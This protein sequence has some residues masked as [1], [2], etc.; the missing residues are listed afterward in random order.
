MTK[1]IYHIRNLQFQ[2]QKTASHSKNR[3]KKFSRNTILRTLQPITHNFEYWP[4]NDQRNKKKANEENERKKRSCEI[5]FGDCV[6]RKN[7]ENNTKM[8]MIFWE[9]IIMG[10]LGDRK[11]NP[12]T[13]APNEQNHTGKITVWFLCHLWQSQP[14]NEWI[15]FLLSFSHFIFTST[16]TK[17]RVYATIDQSLKS[18]VVLFNGS[19]TKLCRSSP[20]KQQQ[21]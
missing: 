10:S 3:E 11:T 4:K 2:Q 18:L 17:K 14:K 8:L 1:T 7:D 15:F 19:T 9:N 16:R 13:L 5:W 21:Q 20:E 6:S 12:Y